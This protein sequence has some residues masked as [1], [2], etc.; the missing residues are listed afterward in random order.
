MHANVKT[1]TKTKKKANLNRPQLQRMEVLG[2]QNWIRW[3]VSSRGIFLCEG[4]V[5]GRTKTRGTSTLRSQLASLTC[6]V[7][8][9]GMRDCIFLIDCGC[10][11]VVVVET[12]R[13]AWVK[14][15]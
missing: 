6:Y 4:V 9:D 15:L 12:C 14:V 3:Q 5:Q 2:A 11:G 1:K 10:E 13:G 8:L 7:L